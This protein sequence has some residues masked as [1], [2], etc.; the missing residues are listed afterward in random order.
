[1][2]SLLEDAFDIIVRG[3]APLAFMAADEGPL[4]SVKGISNARVETIDSDMIL[5]GFLEAHEQRGNH[6]LLLSGESQSRMVFATDMRERS[7]H[8][9]D[10]GDFLDVYRAER[11]LRSCTFH[12]SHL[13]P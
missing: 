5:P 11:F 2:Q 3:R 12:T 13:A 6:P 1:M 4:V 10:Q 9:K 8:F 7:I